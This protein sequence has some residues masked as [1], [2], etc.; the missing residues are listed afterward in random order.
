M[1]LKLKIEEIQR[2]EGE[3]ALDLFYQGIRAD[4]IRE[5]YER[6]LKYILSDMLSD[7]LEGMFEERASQ[8]VRL[9][10]EK[11]DWTRDLLL[12]LSKK[13]HER[14]DL[15]KD[16]HDYLSP[17]HSANTSSQSKNSHELRCFLICSAMDSSSG[18]VGMVR[19]VHTA[20]ISLYLGM[21]C[22]CT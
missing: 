11:P 19:F 15:P 7:I 3:S 21:M 16:D 8:F 5:S 12:C 6:R 14:S 4:A 10:K 1:D 13:L 22:T 2:T 9:A 20:P 17:E 18:G